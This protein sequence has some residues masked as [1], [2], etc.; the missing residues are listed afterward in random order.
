MLAAS[1]ALA[2][3][4]T[5]YRSINSGKST[6][7]SRDVSVSFGSPGVQ[8]TSTAFVTSPSSTLQLLAMLFKTFTVPAKLNP[9]PSKLP[10]AEQDRRKG[11]VKA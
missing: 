1:I 4:P 10:R 5:F 6:I 9:A 7:I 2:I 3:D 11:G 8:K